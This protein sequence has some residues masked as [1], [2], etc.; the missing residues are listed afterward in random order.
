MFLFKIVFLLPE[1]FLLAII[2]GESN[3]DEFSQFLFV[4][5]HLN[6]TFISEEYFHVMKIFN[7]SLVLCLWSCKYTLSVLLAD[8]FSVE[9]SAQSCVFSFEDNATVYS[10]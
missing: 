8:V 2:F 3:S 1:K 6:F 4:W 10:G 9:N 5:K 7:S